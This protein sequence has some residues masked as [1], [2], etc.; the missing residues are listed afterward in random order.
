M[1]QLAIEANAN[2]PQTVRP[3]MSPFVEPMA[4]Q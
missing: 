2:V 4:E 1:V 3:N